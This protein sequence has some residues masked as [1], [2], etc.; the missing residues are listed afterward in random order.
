MRVP[1]ARRTLMANVELLLP[2]VQL[3][4]ASLVHDRH[5]V[6]AAA[7]VPVSTWP[8]PTPRVEPRPSFGFADHYAL[9]LARTLLPQVAWR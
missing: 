9:L 5:D 8:S 4:L 7:G 2:P 3:Q 1:Q 6:L